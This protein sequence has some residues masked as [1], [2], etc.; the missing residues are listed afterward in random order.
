[1][2]RHFT[3]WAT[4]GAHK[5]KVGE[6]SEYEVNS[7]RPS[8]NQAVSFIC[9]ALSGLF[10]IALV[11]SYNTV[12]PQQQKVSVSGAP[13][14]KSVAITIDDLPGAVAG[15][16]DAMGKLK[17][18][19]R[20]NHQVIKALVKHHVPAIG[21]VIER[22]LQVTGERDARA[23]ILKEWIDA[24]MELGNHTYSHIH[25]N[26]TT[27][28]EEEA[29]TLRG[30]VVTKALL[31]EKGKQEHFFRH[32]ALNTGPTPAAKEA[33]D[34]FLKNHGYEVA[35]VTLEDGDYKFDDVLDSARRNHDRQRAEKIKRLYLEHVDFIFNTGEEL[36]QRLFQRQI[37]QILLIHDDELN[38]EMLD[39]LLSDL[40]RRGY[41]FVSLHDA[42]LDSAYD[43][44]PNSFV[45]N[46][47]R[48]YL[49]WDKRLRET[50]QTE[51]YP[52]NSEPSWISAGSA[53]IRKSRAQGRGGN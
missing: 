51:T 27:L 17:E 29:E 13:S 40:A 46:L 16:D 5:L 10:G 53:D 3:A 12:L 21:F 1:M 35:P 2:K 28:Q 19:Q 36:S 22:K 47:G 45:G 50:G 39:V 23:G 34:D 6:Q 38:A 9:R 26:Q 42:L 30:E 49:C 8:E 33:F 52:W 18:L 7:R 32:T 25:F 11:A 41:K 24:G 48:C 44:S 14:V 43:E 20:C 31:K 4:P 15:S 37:P